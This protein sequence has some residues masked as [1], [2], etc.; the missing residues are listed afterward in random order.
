H[1]VVVVVPAAAVP[2]REPCIG[3]EL[4][5]AEGYGG[6]GKRMAVASGADEGIHVGGEVF[7]GVGRWQAEGAGTERQ[8]QP[9]AER[10]LA[11]AVSV[12]QRSREAA[13]SR[14]TPLTM[15]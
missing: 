15:S 13:A 6:P 9:T 3:A 8:P 14:T 2:A 11:H 4:Y 10:R 12:R 1:A 5:H 7:R